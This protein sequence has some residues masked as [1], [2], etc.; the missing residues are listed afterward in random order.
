IQGTLKHSEKLGNETFAYV[1]AGALGD[2]T[3]RMDGTLPL[4][5]GQAIDLAFEAEHLY[6]FDANGKSI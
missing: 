3:A 2:I 1:S 4:E 5:P 6:R